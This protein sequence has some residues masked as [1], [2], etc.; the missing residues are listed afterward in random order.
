[1]IG[2]GAL[3]LGRILG[4]VGE[5]EPAERRAVLLG[6][7]AYLLLLATAYLLRPLR[8]TMATVFGV[9]GLQQLFTLTFTATLLFSPL[10]TWLTTRVRLASLLPAVFAVL[11]VCVL[12]FYLLF[13]VSPGSRVVAGAYYTWY[14]TINLLMI[15]VFWT[16]MVELFSASQATRLFAFIAAGG[17]IGSII[18]AVVTRSAVQSIGI[19]GLL[20]LAAALLA[21]LVWLTLWII[22]EK[23]SLQ[24]HSVEAQSSTM[25]HALSG[26]ALDGFTEV[27][28]SAFM[29]NQ[30][31]FTLLMTWVNTVAYFVQTDLVARSFSG[32]EQR[33]A[34]IADIDVIVNILTAAILC[35]GLS[36]FVRRFGVTAS[37]LLNPLVMI[38][39]FVTVALSPVLL[40]IQAVQVTRRV[41]QY[42][43]ARPARE[44]CFAVV[45]QASRY[46]AK[47]VV[48]TIVYRTGDV[49]AAWLQA[50]LRGAG[51]G[52][53][54]TM[55][56]GLV[57]TGL[58]SA[59]ALALGRQYQRLR[60]E[61]PDTVPRY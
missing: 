56:L 1:M 43:I 5:V 14:S 15:S 59:S 31:W 41:A 51:F 35:F 37:L 12:V 53:A 38:V 34:A 36:R 49:T 2:Q 57:C 32:L 19:G 45:P 20:L 3:R 11:A 6:F 39:A 17:S 44:M 21:S 25:D 28:K 47:N 26:G 18:G 23:S 58:W 52:Y 60:G 27:L 24:L 30:M 29:R 13:R 22:A 40:V 8:D 7:A 61:Q 9:D 48:D 55:A 10:F 16:L 4:M 42:A 50:G 33:A 54:G 46:R